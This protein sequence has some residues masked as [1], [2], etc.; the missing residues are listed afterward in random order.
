M[1]TPDNYDA[2]VEGHRLIT[3]SKIGTILGLN[4]W[5]S[6]IEV[7]KRMQSEPDYGGEAED[8]LRIGQILEEPIID[9]YQ[10]RI[11]PD[12]QVV[13]NDA[14]VRPDDPELATWAAA[15][16]DGFFGDREEHPV[17]FAP[18][19]V[20]EIKT[21]SVYS[22]LTEDNVPP[23]YWVQV[24]WEMLC[25]GLPIADLVAM[26]DMKIFRHTISRDDDLIA[27]LVEMAHEWYQRH[28]VRGEEPPVDGSKAYREHLAKKYG[29]QIGETVDADAEIHD[30]VYHL[31]DVSQEMAR[32]EEE[33]AEIENRIRAWLGERGAKKVIGSIT[34]GKFSLSWSVSE[35][36]RTSWKDVAKALN[37]PADLIEQYTKTITT[38]RL[39]PGGILRG[40]K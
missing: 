15:T 32:L 7:W 10:E 17:Q 20:L 34:A 25:A 22:D 4:P 1:T 8:R 24:Q 11:N 33:K 39:T 28:I 19:G 40:K 35:T 23:L 3:G 26:K 30:L 27:Q 13:R 9:Y 5:Q 37:P 12:A 31:Y 18:R 14:L 6:P 36:A 29:G 16:P 21:A 38:D 2:L